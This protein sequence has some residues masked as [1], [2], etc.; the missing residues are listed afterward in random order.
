MAKKSRSHKHTLKQRSPKPKTSNPFARTRG[1]SVQVIAGVIAFALLAGGSLAHWRI[2]HDE[3]APTSNPTKADS[4]SV[5]S[6][7]ASGVNDVPPEDFDI[8]PI[9]PPTP[10]GYN[11]YTSGGLPPGALPPGVSLPGLTTAQGYGVDDGIRQKFTGKERDNET[12][13]DYFGARYYSSAQGRFTSPD[14]LRSSSREFALLGSGHPTEQALPYADLTNPQTLNKYAYAL[15]NPL[16]YV[17]QDGHKPQDSA[18]IRMQQ[19]IKDLN[20][21]RITEQQYWERLRGGAVG[22]AAAL[23]IVVAAR[24]GAPILS[25][26]SMWGARNPDKVQQ[27]AQGVQEA[28]GGAP[29]LT[30]G[31]NSSLRAAEISTGQRLATQLGV[32]LE[33]S[34]HV[35]AEFVVAGANKTIDAMGTP[36]AYKYFGSGKQFFESIVHHVN[37]SVDYVAIDLQGASRNQT[38]AIE[39]FVGGLKEE[40]RNKIIYVR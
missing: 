19:A 4:V 31:A 29:G 40:Q 17:D 25:A 26:L 13:L 15:N 32:R 35:G 18:D 30:L 12:G 14:E 34:A 20:S 6:T 16:R 10:A 2:T 3:D 8:P 21:G 33:E 38:K 28:A 9:Q 27:I 5:A 37:K 24:G 39:K 22:V 7:S 23:A 36:D 11:A 1:L